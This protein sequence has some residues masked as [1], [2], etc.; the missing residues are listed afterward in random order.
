MKFLRGSLRLNR[1]TN[2]RKLSTVQPK[3]LKVEPYKSL[4]D[5]P[6]T[7]YGSGFERKSKITIQSVLKCP[8]EQIH[9]MSYGH[10]LTSDNGSFDLKEMS[11]L[12]GTYIGIDSS[13]LFWSMNHLEDSRDHFSLK[14]GKSILNYSFNIFDGHI[15]DFSNVNTLASASIQKCVLREGICRE[16]ITGGNIR[17]TLFSPSQRGSYPAVITIFGGNKMRHVREEY[18][19]Y[20]AN[21]GYMTLALPFFGV[22]GLSKTYTEKPIEIEYF[23]EAIEFLKS[24]NNVNGKIGILGHSKGG[25]VALGIMAHL[26]GINAVCTING[27]IV[28]I[29]ADVTYKGHVTKMI[30]SDVGR[31]AINK[32]GTIDISN[33]LDNPRDFPNRIHQFQRSSA[34]L[35]MIVGQEDK[36]WQ[37][38]LFADIAKELMDVEGKENYEIIKYAHSGHFFDLPNTPIVTKTTHPLV[39][40]RVMVDFGGKDKA[41]FS[42]EIYEAWKSVLEFFRKS[43]AKTDSKL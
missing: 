21:Q 18:A 29:G 14:D 40:N 15:S 19:V 4:I 2:M 27:A 41:M 13:G 8:E 11:S 33:T 37:S 22:D 23:E 38:E 39:P 3:D 35:L 30:S 6:V 31:L 42:Q 5:E 34:D 16:E 24:L 20:L 25:D 26:S 32:D 28:S 1:F 17:G 43:L 7:L 36:N 12:G 9:F 10:Y